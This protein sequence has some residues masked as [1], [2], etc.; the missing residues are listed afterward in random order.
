MPQFKGNCENMK[1][2]FPFL[3]SWETLNIEKLAEQYNV[4]M[5]V[6]HM[7]SIQDQSCFISNFILETSRHHSTSSLDTYLVT[8]KD[9]LMFIYVYL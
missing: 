1:Q 5:T 4:H 3:I 2:H 6:C 8:C 7:T 9:A